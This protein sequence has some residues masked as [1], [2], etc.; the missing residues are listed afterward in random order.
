MTLYGVTFQRLL[1][2]L[3]FKLL[4]LGSICIK[5]LIT[6]VHQ[7][8]AMNRILKKPQ[9][10]TAGGISKIQTG[11]LLFDK[12]TSEVVAYAQYVKFRG[13]TTGHGV[14][15]DIGVKGLG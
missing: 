13:S 12:S 11:I 7:V 1:H 10:F 2:H 15:T 14:V 5:P 8:F 3:R 4:F 9:Q 6:R